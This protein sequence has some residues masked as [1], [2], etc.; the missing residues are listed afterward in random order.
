MAYALLHWG[1][2]AR[3][4]GD[5]QQA[6][7]SEEE[8]LG[9]FREL[10][11]KHGVARAFLSLGDVALDQGDTL[12]A[13]A[14]FHEALGWCQTLGKQ[15]ESAWALAN[16]GRAA[17]MQGDTGQATQFYQESLALFDELHDAPG[18]QEVLLEMGRVAHTQGDD[19]RALERYRE[20]LALKRDRGSPAYIVDCLEG[21]AGALGA[22][23]QS[24]HAARLFGAADA[25]RATFDIPL[26][27][28][29]RAAYERDLAIAKARLDEA[30][31][32]AAWAEGRDMTLEH[33]VA[34]ALESTI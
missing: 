21:I 16:L 15:M 12:R 1:R 29:A 4:L 17:S 31:F 14:C 24:T 20:S 10:G 28:A 5:Y 27:P 19:R 34:Y 33:A 26:K 13:T 2:T 30:T 25:L 23:G 11:D 32:A 8:S 18:I 7:R 22:A 9:L 6:Q 3:F